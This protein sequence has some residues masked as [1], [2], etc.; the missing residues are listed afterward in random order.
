ML[1]LPLRPAT[2]THTTT[3][4]LHLQYIFFYFFLLVV[5]FFRF[6]ANICGNIAATYNFPLSSLTY[7]YKNNTFMA[8]NMSLN[9][10][11][12]LQLQQRIREWQSPNSFHAM[13]LEPSVTQHNG[14]LS[15]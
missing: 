2:I 10:Q 15:A 4:R 1:P 7:T 9:I 12:Q 3:N 5:A 11:Q 13:R 14:L 8:G 6:M